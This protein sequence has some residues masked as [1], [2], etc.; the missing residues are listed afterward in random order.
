MPIELEISS[1]AGLP[2][3]QVDR[4]VTVTAF[5]WAAS[6]LDGSSGNTPTTPYAVANATCPLH[7]RMMPTMWSSGPQSALSGSWK[8]CVLATL[9]KRS[10]V[11][12]SS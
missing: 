8:L 9:E 12:A 3:V 2:A 11:V 4:G 6:I 5:T 1:R 10:P 7:V